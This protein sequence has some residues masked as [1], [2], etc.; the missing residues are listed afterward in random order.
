MSKAMTATTD[1][2]WV[3][4]ITLPHKLPHYP[5]NI[6]GQQ[7]KTYSL[8]TDKVPDVL[9]RLIMKFMFSSL[10]N[11]LISELNNDFCEVHAFYSG[12]INDEIRIANA[13]MWLPLPYWHTLRDSALKKFI[14]FSVIPWVENNPDLPHVHV[15]PDIH[16]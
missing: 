14:D 4:Y 16:M 13:P 11:R 12:I 1:E 7:V 15:Y 8:L 5:L 10:H 3:P 2:T 9:S 6:P